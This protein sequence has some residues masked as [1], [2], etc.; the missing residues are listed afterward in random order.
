[1]RARY[2]ADGDLDGRIVRGGL[3]GLKDPA[4]L[5]LSA[6]AGR[7]L[8]SQDRRTIRGHFARYVAIEH[9]TGLILPREGIPI[10]TTIEDLVLIS[11]I[12]MSPEDFGEMWNFN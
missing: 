11:D 1:M 4:V 2:Q 5:R 12:Q 8:V 3:E 9:C 10:A 6:D 7:I